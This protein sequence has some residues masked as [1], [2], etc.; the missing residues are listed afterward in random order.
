MATVGRLLK[1][2]REKQGLALDDI[3][4]KTKVSLKFLAAIE[5]EEYDLLPP[6]SY[7]VGFVRLFAEAV[8]QDGG[9]VSAQF[10]REVGA[11]VD[12]SRSET[13]EPDDN[14]DTAPKRTLPAWA[15]AAA[16]ALI[17][18]AIMASYGLLRSTP[19]TTDP[20]GRTGAAA[21]GTAGR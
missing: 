1:T 16:A 17:I 6:L 7:S 18:L 4:A 9:A 15:I 5:N 11:S 19:K 14:P 13:V 21:T 20:V 10:K 8:G 3:A 2:S 12:P